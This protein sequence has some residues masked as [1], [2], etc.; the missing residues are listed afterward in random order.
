VN[1]AWTSASKKNAA[2]GNGC[3]G[4]LEMRT[5][6]TLVLAGSLVLPTLSARADVLPAGRSN[7]LPVQ[8][9]PPVQVA[10]PA[11]RP[12]G[13]R[14]APRAIPQ[15]QGQDRQRYGQ[16]QSTYT[17]WRIAPLRGGTV[18]IYDDEVLIGSIEAGAGTLFVPQGK[19]YGV[20][21]TR[22]NRVVWQG[23]ILATPG[24]IGLS[25]DRYGQPVVERMPPPP[26]GRTRP[27]DTTQAQLEGRGFRDV[28]AEM[29]SYPDD[30]GRIA[31]VDRV[32]FN[33]PITI[34]QASDILGRFA[35]DE[36][37]LN[38]LEILAPNLIERGDAWRLV[39]MFSFPNSRDQAAYML[40][41]R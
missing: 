17:E 21:M 10:P 16:P 29:D 3:I 12:Y 7:V 4:D 15:Y 6:T 37:R 35:F 38:A 1:L 27:Y 19:P 30:R 18:W 2:D 36:S 11:E 23:H 9:S 13:R 8:S 20:V 39:G 31:V 24:I 32:F 40:G 33:R 25:W 26:T 28:L 41:L 22:G 34:G 5:F 14:Q